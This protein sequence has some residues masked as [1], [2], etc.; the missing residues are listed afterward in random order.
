M[1][2][3]QKK[4]NK[5]VIHR[6]GKHYLLGINKE[7]EKVYLEAPEWCC[8]WYWGFGYIHTF[9]RN[10][11]NSHVHWDS[12]FILGKQKDNSYIH[13]INEVEGFQSV[14]TDEESWALSELMET[15][16]ILRNTADLFHRGGSHVAR[17]PCINILKRS[18]ENKLINETLLPE[19][20]KEIQKIL[21]PNKEPKQ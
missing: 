18:K 8:E 2:N 16:Y 1:N 14:L 15:A 12:S 19:V 13:H 11:I 10:D 5:S 3:T 6:F 9:K 7:G 20:F 17:N 21:T 4:L